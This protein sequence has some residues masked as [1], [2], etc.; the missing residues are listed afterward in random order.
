M[1]GKSVAETGATGA[2]AAPAANFGLSL[3]TRSTHELGWSAMGGSRGPDAG[4]V[5]GI[6]AAAAETSAYASSVA[7][8]WKDA[9]GLCKGLSAAEGPALVPELK[10]MPAGYNIRAYTSTACDLHAEELQVLAM[11]HGAAAVDS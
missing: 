4:L 8:I 10:L 1:S 5:A 3:A 2:A 11:Q 9:K 7:E 6:A